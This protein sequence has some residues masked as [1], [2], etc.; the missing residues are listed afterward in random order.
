[1]DYYLIPEKNKALVNAT[2]LKALCGMKKADHNILRMT[3][4]I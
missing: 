3:Q 1:M 4:F 2:T